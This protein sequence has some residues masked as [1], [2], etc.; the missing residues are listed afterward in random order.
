MYVPCRTDLRCGPPL[1]PAAVAPAPG[2]GCR[3]LPAETH[4]SR[5]PQ[6]YRRATTKVKVKV[7][8]RSA[9]PR[10]Q[11]ENGGQQEQRAVNEHRSSGEYDRVLVKNLTKC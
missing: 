1:A 9:V 4:S 2:T 5:T 7:Q 10:E 8:A 3:C 11:H 6:W